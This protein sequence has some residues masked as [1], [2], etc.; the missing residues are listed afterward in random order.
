[1]I[2]KLYAGIA[3]GLKNVKDCRIYRE[4]V[5]E[6]FVRPCFM[7]TIYDQNHTR[8]IN[9]RLKST[10]RADVLYFSKSK[11][12]YQEECWSINESLAR[13][14]LVP[15]FKIKNR[16]AM[17]EDKVLHFLFDVDCREIRI[18]NTEKMGPMILTENIKEE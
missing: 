17:I 3:A 10:M 7:V 2:S 9:G 16:N 1:M 12:N 14:F 8:G 6:G 11:D 15:G 18:S 13:E 5:P 4:N